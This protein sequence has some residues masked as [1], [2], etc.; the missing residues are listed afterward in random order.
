MSETPNGRPPLTPLFV[1]IPGVVL[2]DRHLSHSAKLLFGVLGWLADEDGRVWVSPLRAGEVLDLED[3]RTRQLY[4]ELRDRGYI[5][6]ESDPVP[7]KRPAVHRLT[8]STTRQD[9]AARQEIAGGERNETAAASGKE[10]PAEEHKLEESPPPGAPRLSTEFSPEVENA[11]APYVRAS[12]FPD[13]V[14]AVIRGSLQGLH[15]TP[16]AS[17]EEIV[18]TLE[19]MKAANVLRFGARVFRAY[20]RG[21]REQDRGPEEGGAAN[22]PR[23]IGP[24]PGGGGM[25][26]SLRALRRGGSQG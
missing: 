6:K 1:V 17:P 2:R 15:V 13:S 12:G 23:R 26:D 19:E 10:V 16:A 4:A 22:V 18:R 11:I 14:R 8:V 21:V 25:A 5:V 9:R 20:L 7:G 3:R 24:R